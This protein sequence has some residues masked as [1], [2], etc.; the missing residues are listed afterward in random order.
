MATPTF[1]Q[2]IT[3]RHF[4]NINFSKI[5]F[6][7]GLNI[8][9]GNNGQ[10]KTNLLE[11]IYIL[12]TLKSFRSN[13]INDLIEWNHNNSIIHAVF[14]SDMTRE[15]N[16]EL[17]DS[18]KVIKLDG[19]IIKSSIE[20][21]K[22]I[23]SVLF[24]P[25]DLN[26]VKGTSAIRRS[27]IDKLI[28]HLFPRYA[29]ILKEYNKVVF[30]KNK[31]LIQGEKK[32]LIMDAWNERQ[33]ELGSKVIYIRNRFINKIKPLFY[34][35]HKD[36][37]RNDSQISISYITEIE[38]NLEENLNEKSIS[39]FF[40]YTLSTLEKEEYRKK[41]TLLGPH[42]DDISFFYNS[43]DASVYCSQGQVRLISLALKIL[44][45]E[46]ITKECG[47][48]PIFLLDDVSSELDEYRNNYL[49]RYLKKSNCQIFITTTS[50]EHIKAEFFNDK[51][52]YNVESGVVV[53]NKSI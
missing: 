47:I 14:E 13:R 2:E 5:N 11:A 34:D 52:V 16:L 37:S 46:V 27:F 12:S 36:V 18:K 50:P 28:F 25:E 21:T 40:S 9:H 19:K 15:I 3:L 1:L 42:R 6:S 41:H 51:F 26:L 7:Y 49:M 48:T 44:E 39:K 30:Q 8:I 31:L 17:T 22:I 24:S 10:G 53:K 29:E 23:K 38:G 33:I 4:R 45:F 43:K 32:S 35:I 20:L